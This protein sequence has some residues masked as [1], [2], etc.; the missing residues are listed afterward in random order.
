MS[1]MNPNNETLHAALCFTPRRWKA[2]SGAARG[3]QAL[4]EDD[5]Q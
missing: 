5:G 1:I 4:P 3:R 2:A